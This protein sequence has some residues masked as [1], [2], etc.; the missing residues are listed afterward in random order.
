MYDIKEGKTNSTFATVVG[1]VKD[2]RLP[3]TTR[4]GGMYTSIYI[5]LGHFSQADR[6]G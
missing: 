2:C 5:W 1:V 4:T 6:L 3:V